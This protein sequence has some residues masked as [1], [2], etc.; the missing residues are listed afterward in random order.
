MSVPEVLAGGASLP[1]AG[2]RVP[3]SSA[4]AWTTTVNSD[5]VSRTFE[6]NR[7]IQCATE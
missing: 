4:R 5:R 3:I 2:A 7:L 6:A 1:A